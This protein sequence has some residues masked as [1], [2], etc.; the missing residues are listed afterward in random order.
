METKQV[1][2]MDEEG[3]IFGGILVDGEYIIC[4]CCGGVIEW[5]EVTI[6]EKYNNWVNI[7]DNIMEGY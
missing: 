1:K 5:N 6:L 3:E 4:G 2:F 7:S